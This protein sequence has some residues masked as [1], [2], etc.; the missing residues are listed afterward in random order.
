MPLKDLLRTSDLTPADL[1]LLLERSASFVR[2]PFQSRTRLQNQTVVLYFNKPS[3]RTRLST[4]T[5]VARLGGTPIMVGPTDLQ[6]GRG[7][8]IEDTAKVISRYASAF[9]IRTF[10][11]E[12]VR[13]FASAASIPVVNALTD[14]HHPMQSLADLLTLQQKHGDLRRI[15]VAWVGDGNNVLHS[16]MEALALAGGHLRVATPEGYGPDPAVVA[17]AQALAAESG[18]TLELGSDPVAAVQ[19]AHAVYT[20]TWFSMGTPEAER[21]ERLAHLAPYQLNR[22]LLDR[23]R[24]DAIAMHCLPDHRGEEITAEVVDGPQS[25]VFDQAENRLHTAAALLCALVQGQLEGRR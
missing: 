20:D 14:G 4:E 17:A 2:D 9:V 13:R 5:A 7:E 22:A 15:R 11:D 16:L 23:A 19:D 24:S 21:A 6:L 3:T 25:V 1:A 12:D 8:T 10:A 18:G